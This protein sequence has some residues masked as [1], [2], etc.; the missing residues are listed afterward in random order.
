MTLTP[1][2]IEKL[3][4]KFEAQHRSIEPYSDIIFA[5][6]AVGPYQNAQIENRWQGYLALA[7]AMVGEEAV[8]RAKHE[9]IFVAREQALAGEGISEK[10]ARATILA[11]LGLEGGS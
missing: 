8:E 9:M 3:R 11:A 6:F 7:S 1:E 4:A 10:I 5:R 2:Q